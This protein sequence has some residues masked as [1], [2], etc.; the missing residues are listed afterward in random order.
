MAA[1][2]TKFVGPNATGSITDLAA[3]LVAAAGGGD[4]FALTGKEIFIALNGSGGSITV[5]LSTVVAA[6]PDNYGVIN[7]AHD[8]T[9]VIPAGKWGL[10]GA[11]TVPRFRDANGN[12]QVTY[13]AVTTL[14][15]G[16]FAIV[17]TA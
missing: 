10:W 12:A 7:A 2:T 11:F 14:T 9:L 17:Q 5:T 3:Q 16:V 15:V 6:A 1:L 8:I 4:S 13:S